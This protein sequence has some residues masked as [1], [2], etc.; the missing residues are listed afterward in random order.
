MATVIDANPTQVYCVSTDSPDNYDCAACSSGC[1]SPAAALGNRWPAGTVY[2]NPYG[3]PTGTGYHVTIDLGIA[4]QVQ[5]VLWANFGDTVH[6]TPSVVLSHSNDAVSFTQVASLD[7]TAYLGSDSLRV[8]ALPTPYAAAARY[9]KMEIAT[10]TSG[11]QFLARTLGLCDTADCAEVPTPYF[12]TSCGTWDAA[13]AECR[14]NGGDLVV[15]LDAAK[16]SQ[17]TAF[18]QPFTDYEQCGEAYTWIGASDCSASDSQCSWVDGSPWNY[19]GPGFA[20]DDSHAHYYLDGSW[21]TW[22]GG[23]A[24]GICEHHFRTTSGNWTRYAIVKFCIYTHM[25]IHVCVCVCVHT[26]VCACV[27]VCMHASIRMRTCLT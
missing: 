20:V 21:G 9:W 17:V 15:I 5:A 16:N 1:S 26:C 13:R 8:V 24:R 7:L 18:M 12:R 6:D 14:A 19:T 3:V 2:W 22:S 27:C 25:Y 11:F 4:T 10:P 23:T